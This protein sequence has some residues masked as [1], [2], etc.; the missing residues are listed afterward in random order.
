MKKCHLQY[1][2]GPRDDHIKSARKR[3]IPYDITYM[4][5][6]KYGTNQHIYK[7]KRDSQIQRIDLWLLRG[8]EAGKEGLGVWG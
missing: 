8:R 3:Q 1:M 7:T 2:Y 4:C 6:L 5:K